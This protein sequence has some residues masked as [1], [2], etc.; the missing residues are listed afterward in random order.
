[1]SILVMSQRGKP[2][3]GV[4]ALPGAFTQPLGLLSQSA[5]HLEPRGLSVHVAFPL[6]G[7]AKGQASLS[8]C[9]PMDTQCISEGSPIQGL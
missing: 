3:P 5:C 6:K 2:T 9:L 4:S 1:M 7:T 8:I